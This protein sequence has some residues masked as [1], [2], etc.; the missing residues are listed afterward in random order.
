M[1][2]ARP[3]PRAPIDGVATDTWPGHMMS[4]GATCWF[5][6]AREAAMLVMG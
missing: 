3:S 2:G 4:R 5:E 6:Q 1:S